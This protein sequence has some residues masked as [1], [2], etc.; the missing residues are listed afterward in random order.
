MNVALNFFIKLYF[1][2]SYKLFLNLSSS[3][4]Y[5]VNPHIIYFLIPIRKTL[6]M[7]KLFFLYFKKLIQ[8]NYS[9]TR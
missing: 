1:Y 3:K 7:S 4:S 6:I 2:P 9:E 8:P 5:R